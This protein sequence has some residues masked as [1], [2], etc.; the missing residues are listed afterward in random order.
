MS[1]LKQ[2]RLKH[3]YIL[4]MLRFIFTLF[5]PDPKYKKEL[6][7]AAILLAAGYLLLLALVYSAFN[8]YDLSKQGDS[9]PVPKKSYTHDLRPVVIHSLESN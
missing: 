1:K 4:C 7:A 9:S 8:D 3:G 2:Y 5:K 6:K